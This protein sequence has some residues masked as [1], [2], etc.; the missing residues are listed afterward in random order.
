M[1]I[2]L[3][4]QPAS[5]GNVR[6]NN[7]CDEGEEDDHNHSHND[8]SDHDDDDQPDDATQTITSAR[9][10]YGFHFRSPWIPRPC[11]KI[12]YPAMAGL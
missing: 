9:R 2:L 12:N 6:D 3:A 11:D 4:S 1:Q 7:L 10:N 8:D 5:L